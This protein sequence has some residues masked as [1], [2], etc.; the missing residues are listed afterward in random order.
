MAR[1]LF[2]PETALDETW[3]YVVSHGGKN[4]ALFTYISALTPVPTFASVCHQIDGTAITEEEIR[5]LV[6]LIKQRGGNG[7][8][9]FDGVYPWLV[10]PM[11]R[12]NVAQRR[13]RKHTHHEKKYS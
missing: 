13:T 11:E 10:T 12:D 9:A 5:E 8:W 6:A 1:L 4:F 7:G 3:A 2:D